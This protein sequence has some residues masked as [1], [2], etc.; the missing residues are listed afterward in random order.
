V[1]VEPSAG[2]EGV[3]AGGSAGAAGGSAGAGAE[4]VVV[5]LSEAGGVVLVV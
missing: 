1:V 3:A 2:A 4:P 5:E